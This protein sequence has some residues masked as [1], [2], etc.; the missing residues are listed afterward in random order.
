MSKTLNA[1]LNDEN[2]FIVSAELVLVLTIGVLAMVV[3]LHSVAKSVTIE[4][5]DISN[6]LGAMNQS[7]KYHGLKKRGHSRAEG[8]EFVDRQDDCDCNPIIE[9]SPNPKVDG[10]MRPS[11]TA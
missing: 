8:A 5:N 4:L 9:F 1:L 7:Y 6:A 10:L 2:G 3:G 11:L